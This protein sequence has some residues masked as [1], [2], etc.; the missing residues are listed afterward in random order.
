VLPFDQRLEKQLQKSFFIIQKFISHK[1]KLAVYD[2]T[3]I[4]EKYHQKP[5]T[6]R[7]DIDLKSKN[8]I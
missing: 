2:D 6:N 1:P 3:R 5:A 8:L 7:P 4:I